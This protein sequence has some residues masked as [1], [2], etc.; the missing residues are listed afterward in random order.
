MQFYLAFF[1]L[2]FQRAKSF[3]DRDSI[4]IIKIEAQRS[5]M[6][7]VV[8]RRK[9]I[10]RLINY[11]SAGRLARGGNTSVVGRRLL[12][13]S[14]GFFER[15]ERVHIP[16]GGGNTNTNFLTRLTCLENP[17]ESLERRG[18]TLR[19]CLLR[20]FAFT[21]T[22]LK[23]RK[24]RKREMKRKEN[25]RENADNANFARKHFL[26][27]NRLNALFFIVLFAALI[28]SVL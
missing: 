18:G 16:G 24:R 8:M 10:S 6:L 12:T 5:K 7:A 20:K 26:L 25:E 22:T 14:V 3:R 19:K 9:L 21:T 11:R 2:H 27:T 23:T 15:S 1:F 28:A 17:A 4:I 13:A